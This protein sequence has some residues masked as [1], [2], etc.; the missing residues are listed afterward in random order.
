MLD[1]S[2]TPPPEDKDKVLTVN[3]ID[4]DAYWELIERGY[5]VGFIVPKPI[6]GGN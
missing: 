3:V 6:R 5:W 2:K 4:V 1:D